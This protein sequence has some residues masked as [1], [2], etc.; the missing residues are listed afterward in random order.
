VSTF[1]LVHGAWHGAWCWERL[2]PELERRGHRTV[3]VDLPCD[4]P[5]ASFPDYADRVV[6]ALEGTDDDVVLVGHSLGGMTIPLVAARRPVR[7]LVYLCALVPIPGTSMLDQL[8][9]EP[10]TFVPGYEAGLAPAGDSRTR[11]WADVAVARETMYGDC[12]EADARWAF[13]RLRPQS[14]AP[15]RV[16]CPLDALPSVPARYVLCAEDRIVD[17]VRSRRAA[18]ERLGVEPVALP[19]SHSPYLSRPAALADVLVADAP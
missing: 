9:T 5:A 16:P 17:P 2:V 11:R 10:D 19:G 6:R 3:T 13:E 1:A 14:T 18:G 7:A 12:T 15:Y 4:D 8:R